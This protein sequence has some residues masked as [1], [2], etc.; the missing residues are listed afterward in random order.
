M[1][2][3]ILDEPE[4]HN[5]SLGLDL[6]LE[7]LGHEQTPA[8]SLS[9]ALSK[10]D[11]DKFDA[12]IIHHHDYFTIDALKHRFPNVLFCGDSANVNPESK[13]GTIGYAFYKKMK[14]NYDIIIYKN[15]KETISEIKSRKINQ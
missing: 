12:V 1:K 6:L 15:L 11:E 14:E 9:E 7:V 5:Q 3:L 2:F 13:P 8:H 10:L 4:H